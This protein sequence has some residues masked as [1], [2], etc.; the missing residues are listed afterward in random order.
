MNRPLRALYEPSVSFICVT[1]GAP[2][3]C[4]HMQ[5][6]CWL[7]KD[8]KQ[9]LPMENDH[10]TAES[11]IFWIDSES[12]QLHWIQIATS[13]KWRLQFYEIELIRTPTSKD[14]ES[15]WTEICCLMAPYQT[16]QRCKT[17]IHR[18]TYAIELDDRYKGTRI[19]LLVIKLFSY[20]WNGTLSNGWK[21]YIRYY[22]GLHWAKNSWK[23][24][25]FQNKPFG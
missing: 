11:T 4:L 22:Y 19:K 7:I 3:F 5:D 1:L 17:I 25:V 24:N 10:W 9:P 13:T 15:F 18:K 23:R 2:S 12:P 14:F 8:R 21:H 6:L 20:Y 16:L